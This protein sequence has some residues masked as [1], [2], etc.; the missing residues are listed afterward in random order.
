[1]YSELIAFTRSFCQQISFEFSFRQ[2]RNI[3]AIP[4]ILLFKGGKVVRQQVGALPKHAIEK[5]FAD[6]L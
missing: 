6:Q 3:S 4:T 2:Y 1:M 5:L